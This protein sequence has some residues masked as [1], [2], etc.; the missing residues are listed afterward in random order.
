MTSNLPGKC[1]ILC[2]RHTLSARCQNSR[3]DSCRIF[4][5]SGGVGIG[6]VT[7]V[8]HQGQKIKG[9]GYKVTK[10]IS[11][12]NAITWQWKVVATSNMV[13]ILYFYIL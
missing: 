9:Q 1:H 10:H 8:T 3:T 12:Y 2:Y 7:P 5:V 6:H 13:K 11:S 4:K